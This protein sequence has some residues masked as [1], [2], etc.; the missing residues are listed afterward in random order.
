MQG[1]AA[2][3]ASIYR[4]RAAL[5]RNRDLS[6]ALQLDPAHMSRARLQGSGGPPRAGASRLQTRART[7]SRA[8]KKPTQA[9]VRL[10]N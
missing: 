8:T 7:E 10:K 6:L 4:Q 5:Y 1:A 3:M 2:V 9:L